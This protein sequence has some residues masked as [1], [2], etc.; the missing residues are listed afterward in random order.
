MTDRD[1]DAGLVG[2]SAHGGKRV[3]DYG[4]SCNRVAE[5]RLFALT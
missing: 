5:A 4:A 2:D 3:R 1:R